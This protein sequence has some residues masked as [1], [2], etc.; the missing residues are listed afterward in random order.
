MKIKQDFV[1]NS[2]TT[3]YLFYGYEIDNSLEMLQKIAKEFYEVTIH[4]EEEFSELVRDVD[5]NEHF[6][7]NDYSLLAGFYISA[8][9]DGD[10]SLDISKL[11][12]CMK[13]ETIEYMFVNKI[14]NQLVDNDS[15]LLKDSLNYDIRK[16]IDNLKNKF[17]I[18][19]KC[20][21]FEFFEKLKKC[22][23]TKH[24]PELIVR[25]INS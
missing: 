7:L 22:V 5:E 3:C 4:D 18:S 19:N 25:T 23:D 20:E 1:T 8:R 24:E 15:K 16:E 9:D 11:T 2:S 17:K 14:I 12:Y 13:M 21:E 10:I 6:L